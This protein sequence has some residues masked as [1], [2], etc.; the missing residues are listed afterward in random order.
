MSG[1]LLMLRYRE[2]E[3]SAM[4]RA[5]LNLKSFQMLLLLW[6]LSDLDEHSGQLY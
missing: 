1:A 2:G 6:I 5:A 4:A 3:R